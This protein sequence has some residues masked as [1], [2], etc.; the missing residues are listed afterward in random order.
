MKKGIILSLALLFAFNGLCQNLSFLGIPIQG[1]ESIFIQKLKNSGFSQ[2]TDTTYIGKFYSF[3][4]CIVKPIANDEEE[5][6]SVALFL[7]SA[8][9]W[10]ALNETYNKVRKTLKKEYGEIS[11]IKEEFDTPTEPYSAEEKLEAL[12]NGKCMYMTL[13]AM[14]DGVVGLL[15]KHWESGENVVQIVW[16]REDLLIPEL[17][18]MKFK[19]IPFNVSA[20]EFVVRMQKQGYKYESRLNNDYIDMTGDFA[21]YSDCSIYINVVLPDNVI[22]LVNVCFPSQSRWSHLQSTYNNIKGMLIEKYGTPSSSIEEFDSHR[23]PTLEYDAISL[24]KQDKYK[25][26]TQ[27]YVEGGIIQLDIRHVYVNYEHVFY[28][29]LS[30]YDALN[31]YKSTKKAI[32]DL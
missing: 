29:S 19:G 18:H 31:Q 21:G 27:F 6:T 4:S 17:P 25:Y 26:E 9:S 30:Y 20:E 3:D 32:D 11:R 16:M 7:P 15:I 28:V 8:D 14:N 2:Y 24:L 23:P 10:T 13:W 22:G 12:N 5:M 1:R